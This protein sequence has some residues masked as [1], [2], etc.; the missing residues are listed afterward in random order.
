MASR[1]WPDFCPEGTLFVLPALGVVELVSSNGKKTLSS[2]RPPRGE[3]TDGPLPA[4]ATLCMSASLLPSR[5]LSPTLTFLSLSAG[6]C[7]VT[8][9]R[10]EK[11]ED[12][13]RKEKKEKR[14]R[15]K[16]EEGRRKREFAASRVHLD[17]LVGQMSVRPSPSL[18][19]A[20]RCVRGP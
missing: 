10:G 20:A 4:S 1:P 17:I 13:K 2:V 16:K 11:E 6:K 12:K 14:E 19:T 15:R 5:A 3:G 8:I 9:P 18:L 7:P